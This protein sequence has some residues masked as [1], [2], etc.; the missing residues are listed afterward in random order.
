MIARALCAGLALVLAA[1]VSACESTADKS[2]KI[3]T[4]CST[5]RDGLTTVP[6][7]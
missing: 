4:L 3:G 1:G 7:R 5:L 2:A 6:V